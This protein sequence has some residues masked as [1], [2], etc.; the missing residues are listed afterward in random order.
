MLARRIRWFFLSILILYLWFYPGTALIPLLG[1]FSPTAE[2]VNEAVLRISSL[3]IVIS[4]SVMLVQLTPREQIISGI[5][6]LLLPLTAVGVNT[7]RFA[8]RLGL[9]LAIVPEL[10]TRQ[11]SAKGPKNTADL[12]AA[13]DRAAVMVKQASEPSDDFALNEITV[14]ELSRPGALD[15]IIP[16]ALL[17]WLLMTRFYY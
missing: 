10:M 6:T 4:Y 2:G 3:L 5:Q 12:S 9:V 17:T 8:L 11:S 14:A 15:I 13:L 16:L 1:R 7:S